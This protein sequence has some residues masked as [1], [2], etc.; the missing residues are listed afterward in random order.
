MS[1]QSHKGQTLPL[2]NRVIPVDTNTLFLAHYDITAN[3]VLR[4]IAPTGTP[5]FT[6]RSDGYFGGGI[7]V[8]ESTVN[9][10]ASPENHSSFTK[11][12][13][14]ITSYLYAT[15][16]SGHSIHRIQKASGTSQTY[17]SF[18]QCFPV[19]AGATYTLSFKIK[20]ISGP[21][22]NVVA[23]FGGSN[24]ASIAKRDIGDGW[25]FCE[26]TAPYGGTG[27]CVGI[28]FNGTEALDLLA[29]ELQVEQKLFPT[30]FIDG[31]R[32]ISD[33]AYPN[34]LIQGAQEGT[35]VFWYKPSALSTGYE[36]LVRAS[37]WETGYE[38]W[39]ILKQD[40]SNQIC[41]EYGKL[42]TLVFNAITPVDVLTVNE[43]HFVVA[44]W[45]ASNIKISVFKQDG[46]LSE[47]S[48]D[49]AV[50]GLNYTDHIQIGRDPAS[51]NYQVNGMFDELRIDSVYRSDDEILAWYYSN[52]P[53]WPKGIYTVGY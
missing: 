49:G 29:T 32:P 45:R 52:S 34:S 4:G 23:H 30:S 20:M 1:M 33:L 26:Y 13:G 50:W 21:L 40:N 12:D 16:A 17:A 41:F 8:E 48:T 44:R 53:F 15:S 24:K 28:G 18:R 7:A 47:A 43:W 11:P 25:Y 3:D 5:V 27:L 14:T 37:R 42:G 9:L 2:K 39:S 35:V 19:T 46:T 31:T 22:N 38:G 10:Y 6:M 51:N 36:V